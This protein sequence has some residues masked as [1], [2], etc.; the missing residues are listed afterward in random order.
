MLA[1]CL[2]GVAGGAGVTT[3]APPPAASRLIASPDPT[4]A[5]LL[6]EAAP[7]LADAAQLRGDASVFPGEGAVELY[8]LRFEQVLPNGLSASVVQRVFQLRDKAA[9]DFFALDDLWYDSARN[10]FQLCSAQ[11]LRAGPEPGAATAISGHDLGDLRPGATGNQPRRVGLP[12]LRAGDRVS[13]LYLLLPDATHDWRSLEGHYLGNLFA[14]RDSFATLHS[15]YVVAAASALTF[16][17]VGVAPAMRSRAADGQNLWE[18]QAGA[19]PAIFGSPGGPSITDRSPFVQVSGFDSWAALAGWYSNLLARRAQLQPA[20]VHRWLEIA[21]GA[22]LQRPGNA[23]AARATVARIWRY[24]A[25]R[26]SYRGDERGV[27]AYVPAAVD[28]VFQRGQGDCKDGALL[29]ATWLRAAGVDADLALVRTT[30]MGQ[31]APPRGD[32]DVPATMA[33]FDHALVYV[34]LT[35]QWID[36]TA[37]GYLADELPSSDQNS[38]ALIV[39]AGQRELVR[40]PA[41]PAG[42]N[43]TRRTVRLTPVGDGSVEAS[44]T[45]V[46]SGADAPSLRQDYADVANQRRQLQRW[47]DTYFSDVAVESVAV[48]GV[49]P[50]ADTVAIAFRARIP[51]A[52][53]PTTAWIQRHYARLLAFQAVR[54][55]PLELPLCWRTDETWTLDQAS[56]S[57]GPVPVLHRTSAYGD[58]A[59]ATTCSGGAL[60][61]HSEVS[62]TARRIEPADYAAFRGFWQGVDAALNAPVPVAA[63]VAS[64]AE[65]R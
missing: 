43:W 62:Q 25:P 21:G 54:E 14:F 12:K 10:Q 16:S 47:L 52:S 59:I 9:A 35:R 26:L 42:A 20:V 31:L 51:Q 32:G 38:L 7:Y 13:V 40:V 58:L 23:G 6:R 4:P 63:T 64:V 2:L 33:A 61:V 22:A 46:V 36:T 29:L 39:R 11:V 17:A 53:A 30:A 41:A 27:H 50:P 28:A 24:L 65:R 55:T 49:A 45:I 8:H 56:C 37:P 15:R 3:A 5:A 18:W 19:L 57:A 48:T 34:P 44:G 60:S 1:V